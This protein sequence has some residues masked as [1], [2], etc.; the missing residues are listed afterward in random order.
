MKISRR[1]LVEFVRILLDNSLGFAPSYSA[2]S[3]IEHSDDF[4]YILFTVGHRSYKYLDVPGVG[5]SVKMISQDG[6]FTF[7]G[8][9]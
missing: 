3:I 7:S 5:R 1:S 4:G 2:V 6:N 8:Q 9:L